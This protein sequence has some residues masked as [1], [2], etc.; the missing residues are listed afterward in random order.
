MRTP[1]DAPIS[2]VVRASPHTEIYNSRNVRNEADAGTNYDCT[3]LKNAIKAQLIILEVAALTN[4][5]VIVYS[6][7]LFAANREQT[8]HPYSCYVANLKYVLY[9]QLH[10]LHEWG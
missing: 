7:L 6:L 10:Q 5:A 4:T 8:P 9:I 3:A 1:I 2:R